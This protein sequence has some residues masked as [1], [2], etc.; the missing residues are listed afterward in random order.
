[1]NRTPEADGTVFSKKNEK[2]I[3][4]ANERKKLAESSGGLQKRRKERKATGGKR[5]RDSG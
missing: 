1:M 5:K 4:L 3:R 2:T